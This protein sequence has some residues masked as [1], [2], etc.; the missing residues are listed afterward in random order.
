TKG[1]AMYLSKLELQGF[2]SFADRTVLHFDEGI[3]AIVGPNGCGKSNLV[4]AV[5]WVIGEQRARVLRSERMEHVI[6][7]GTARRRP[8]GMA[9]VL[10]TIE[11]TQGILPLHFSEVTIGRRLYR[12]GES[13]YLLNG[14]PCRLRDIQEL[15]MDTG[16]GAGAYSVIELK[17]IEDILS[18]NAQDRR[19]LFEEAAGI[20]RYKLRR[21]QTLR[22]LDATRND[23]I[24]LRDLIEEVQRQ[25]DSLKRQASRAERYRRY[26]DELQSL[27]QRLLRYDYDR[28]REQAE[29]LESLLQAVQTRLREA[30]RRYEALEAEQSALQQ[31][32]TQTEAALETARERLRTLQQ[33][34]QTLESESRLLDERLQSAR[35]EQERLQ[36]ESEEAARQTQRLQQTLKAT[37][38]A[39]QKASAEHKQVEAALRQ[40]QAARAT[41]QQELHQHRQRVQDVRYQLQQAEQAIH[42][43]HRQ[44]DRQ[45][46][47]REL[48]AQEQQRLAAEQEA[49][50]AQ[51]AQLETE[52][53][54]TLRRRENARQACEQLRQQLE[55]LEARQ[56][57]LRQQIATCDEE[58]HGQERLLEAVRAEARLLE[59]LLT[60]YEDFPE[61]VPFLA[62]TSGWTDAPL[63]TVADLLGITPELQPALDAALGERATW[64]VVAT[65][66]EAQQAL[67]LLRD[68]EKGRATFIV[69]EGLPD[70][71]ALLEVP[72]ARPLLDHVRLAHPDLQP[73]AVWLLYNAYLVD[74]LETAR[75]LAQST[76]A[77]A[78]FFT[79]QGEWIDS[80]SWWHGG[81]AKA[82][83]SPLSGRLDRRERLATLQT[84][85][86]TLEASIA[87]LRKARKTLTQQLQ[88]LPLDQQQRALREAEQQLRALEQ[89]T[90]RQEAT[91]ETL[92]Q[93]FQSLEARRQQLNSEREALEAELQALQQKLVATEQTVADRQAVLQQAETILQQ[94]EAAYQQAMESLHQ[95]Q[96]QAA[97]SRNHLENLQREQQQLR[98][99]LEGIDR[100][101]QERTRQLQ[102]LETRLQQDQQRRRAVEEERRA[103]AAELPP[104]EAEV[105]RLRQQ[106]VALRTAFERTERQL[107]DLR[108]AYEQEQQQERQ[109]Q[110]Q[111]AETRTRLTGLA[112]HARE[113]LDVTDL[114]RLPEPPA[115]FDVQAARE[116]VETLRRRLSGLGTVN[117][118]A[119]EQY[120]QE[121]ERLDFLLRQQQDLESAETTLETTIHEINQTAASRFLETFETIR[122]NFQEL[123]RE[124]FGGDAQADLQLTDPNNPLESPIEI[125]ARPRGKRPSTLAQLSG[126]EK[127]LTAIALLF[128]L[129]L[130]KPSPFCIL[131][132]VDAPLDEANVERF[133]RLL[134]SFSENTQFILITHNLRTMELSDRL[135]GVTMQEP[136]VSTLV[137]VRLEEAAELAER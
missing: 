113:H 65:P 43:A 63:Q 28:L 80:R 118:L 75:R 25:V 59:Q 37:E 124:L 73:L 38:Q 110:V 132:E 77:P 39:L 20:T 10:L 114:A 82:S 70:P 35:R 97:E 136:G 66:A 68:A 129:Y 93:R 44:L 133:M 126:G 69:L 122:R 74:D 102:T 84:K 47:R 104:V 115:N 67:Q 51:L 17:M 11:N 86:H 137:S 119:L 101:Q 87:R 52:Q 55:Q 9:E 121:K 15:F 120:Q 46:N 48:L 56:Q 21:T 96:L 1:T 57:E 26:R 76:S 40:A 135:Y 107:R 89:Q 34:L 123:F 111:L 109:Y 8:V 90:T 128:A 22:K 112:E 41:A 13:E 61:A 49:L 108:R 100:R 106:L 79:P 85:M 94:A 29:G 83:R 64:I 72:G 105:Q 5:R 117:E 98:Q 14:T 99:R 7:N 134:R 18:D 116:Q 81:S 23:L 3:T 54:Q 2:K 130:T 16:M 27:E 50:Q 33:R 19:H 53:A 6:F 31:Q 36:R 125:L 60:A 45:R 62:R 131:D 24:R 71:P 32:I 92:R 88:A 78:R 127:A 42:E 95:V 12:S 91:R 103:R 30:R 4:D 58:L